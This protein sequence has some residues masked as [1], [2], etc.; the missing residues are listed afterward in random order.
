MSRLFTKLLLVATISIGSGMIHTAYADGE[1]RT[2]AQAIEIAKKRS[3][4]GRV[5]SVKKKVN[6]NGLSVFAVKIITDGRVK[7][8]TVREF[9]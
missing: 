2:R 3:G 9:K 4:E 5:L 8:Y 6:N 7:V 1:K